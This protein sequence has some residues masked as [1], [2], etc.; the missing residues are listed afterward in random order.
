[1]YE[2]N[3]DL[4][5]N[6]LL[7]GGQGSLEVAVGGYN[8]L[9]R[10]NLSLFYVLLLDGSHQFSIY[11]ETKPKHVYFEKTHSYFSKCGA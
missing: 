8:S 4:E 1:M 6:L 7:F 2:L 9:K 11:I 5:Y 3:I 10:S